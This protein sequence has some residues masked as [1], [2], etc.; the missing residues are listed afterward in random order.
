MI[1]N[2]FLTNSDKSYLLITS[3]W[4]LLL[5]SMAKNTMSYT[6]HFPDAIIQKS[7]TNSRQCLLS[8]YYD[9][10]LIIATCFIPTTT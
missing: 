10:E 5:N 2:S 8:D 7:I 4:E 1:N 9:P 6:S 3:K